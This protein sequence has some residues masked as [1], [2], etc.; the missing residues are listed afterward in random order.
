MLVAAKRSIAR[1]LVSS[2]G[3]ALFRQLTA[4]GQNV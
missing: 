1:L 2:V 4:P 3:E